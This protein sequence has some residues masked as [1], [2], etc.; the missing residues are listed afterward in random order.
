VG[1]QA[2]LDSRTQTIR[3]PLHTVQR[4]GLCD[5]EE[6]VYSRQHHA[7]KDRHGKTDGSISDRMLRDRQ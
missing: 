2:L 1:K 7:V 3:T 4:G 6:Q 5:D